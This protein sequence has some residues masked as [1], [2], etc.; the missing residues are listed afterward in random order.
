MTW[1]VRTLVVEAIANLAANRPR[2]LALVLVAALCFGALAFLEV[3]EASSLLAFQQSYRDAGGYI[4]VV[5]GDGGLSGATCDSI[6]AVPGVLAAGAVSSAGQATFDS[7]P[8]VLFQSALVTWPV[9]RIWAPAT[10]V[11]PPTSPYLLAGPA[12]ASELGVRAG[13]FVQPSGGPPALL[14][15]VLDTD[16]RNPQASRWLI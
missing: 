10:P 15:A 3:R 12:L 13:L 8:G 5:R 7:Q 2:T 4:A 1:R 6:N 14:A 9:A 11:I 16:E